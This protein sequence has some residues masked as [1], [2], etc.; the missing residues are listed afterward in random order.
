MVGGLWD[1]LKLI[2]MN[3]I[4]K[5]QGELISACRN[6]NVSELYVFGSIL[7]EA[8]HAQSD[9]DF[10]VSINSEDPIE[11]AENYFKLKFALEDIFK[12]EIDLLE[13]KAI[14]NKTFAD[15]VNQ[16]KKLVYARSNKS[17]A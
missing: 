4:D 11:Y 13:Q 3:L 1:N 16:K 9:I 5:H 10:I 2:D 8:F 14:R 6:S 15:L 12:R 17:V 7:T